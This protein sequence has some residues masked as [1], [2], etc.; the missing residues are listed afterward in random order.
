MLQLLKY[1]F[2]NSTLKNAH[3][4]RITYYCISQERK[5]LLEIEDIPCNNI[6]WTISYYVE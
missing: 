2:Y 1:S 5:F 4:E 6:R 3:I